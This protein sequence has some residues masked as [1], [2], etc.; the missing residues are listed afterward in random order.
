MEKSIE[1]IWKEGFLKGDALIAPKLN[2]LYNQK[3]KHII[4]KFK[5][6]FK[7]NLILI[8]LGSF[9]VLGASFIVGL[10]Y[11]G[12]PMFIILN[13][14]VI[15]NKKLLNT[16]MLIDK[17]RNSYDYLMTFDTWLKSQVNINKKFARFLYPSIFL[18]L[19]VGFW[20]KIEEG[21]RIGEHT[22]NKLL[23]AYPDL[24]LLNGVPVIGII[25]ALLIAGILMLLGGRIYEWDLKIVYGRVFNKLDEIIADVK[26]L[27]A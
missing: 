9:I 5:R 4:D 10:P 7:M 11:M 26:E 19:V 17:S 12:V 15:I 6:M 22:V 14:L 3:S 13:V 23:I 1:T 2:N 20:M 27:R 21:Q 18:S 25:G 24:Y 16:L 8:V